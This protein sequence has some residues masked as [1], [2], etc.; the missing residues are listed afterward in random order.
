MMTR[1][2]GP[3]TL[4][5]KPGPIPPP[6]TA[7]APWPGGACWTGTTWRGTS[8]ACTP[9]MPTSRMRKSSCTRIAC[10]E[11]GRESR[12]R[13]AMSTSRTCSAW[14][15][16]GGVFKVGG[17]RSSG[18]ETSYTTMWGVRSW[19]RGIRRGCARIAAARWRL[20]CRGRGRGFGGSCCRNG[21]CSSSSRSF[22]AYYV[23]HTVVA[24]FSTHR[25]NDR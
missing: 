9:P 7:L 13:P 12:T 18:S 25:C 19:R 15:G 6:D 5:R 20:R 10:R 11:S 2:S 23:F 3:P 21:S 17:T 8:T 16:R 14:S 24:T 1:A 22:V 4:N